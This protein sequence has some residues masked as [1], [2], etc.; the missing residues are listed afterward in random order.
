EALYQEFSRTREDGVIAEVEQAVV[1]A[2]QQLQIAGNVEAALIALQEAE[3][4]LA[5]HDRGQLAGLRR[6]LANDIDAL[7]LQPVLDVSGLSLRLERSM[8]VITHY[9]RLLDYIVPDK[10]HVLSQGRIV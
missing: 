9:Q 2:A 3:S 4:R 1:L 10:V 8:I 5:L 7:K 6:A